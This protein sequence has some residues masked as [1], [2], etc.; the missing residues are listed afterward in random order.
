MK[1]ELS[2]IGAISVAVAADRQGLAPMARVSLPLGLRSLD[3]TVA[4]HAR[5]HGISQPGSAPVQRFTIWDE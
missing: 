2:L 1:R 5:H 3:T 4:N